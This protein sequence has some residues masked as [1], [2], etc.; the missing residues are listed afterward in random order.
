MA[1]PSQSDVARIIKAVGIEGVSV[2]KAA[3]RRDLDFCGTYF[4][5][6]QAMARNRLLRKDLKKVEATALKLVKLLTR[7]MRQSL[8]IPAWHRAVVGSIVKA[9]SR[10][11]RPRVTKVAEVFDKKLASALGVQRLSPFEWLVGER[12]P[13]VFKKHFKVEAGYTRNPYTD[14]GTVES[15]YIRFAMECLKIFSV[16]NNGKPYSAESIARAMSG[17]KGGKSRRKPKGAIS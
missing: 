15:P 17:A 3:L 8:D 4:R 5:A 16:T 10:R 9:A 2:D 12:L 6:R 13:H 11:L 1:A 14:P 7:Q